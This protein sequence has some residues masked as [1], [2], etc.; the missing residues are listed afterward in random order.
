M[1]NIKCFGENLPC[2]DEIQLCF[3]DH[4]TKPFWI[5]MQ[6]AYSL[7]TVSKVLMMPTLTSLSLWQPAVPSAMTNL[8]SWW[9]L[10]FLNDSL[11]MDLLFDILCTVQ[12][13]F[14]VFLQINIFVAY[15]L[16]GNEQTKPQVASFVFCSHVPYMRGGIIHECGDNSQS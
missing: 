8:A 9:H 2:Q 13:V 5:S 1:K 7:K 15:K 6:C 12:F 11:L 16:L 14:G 10:L 3:M 4:T